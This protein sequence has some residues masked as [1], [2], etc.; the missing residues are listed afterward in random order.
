VYYLEGLQINQK[1][2][3][4]KEDARAIIREL[5]FISFLVLAIALMMAYK[6]YG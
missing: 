4:E 6:I 1:N 2:K 5:R 3:M